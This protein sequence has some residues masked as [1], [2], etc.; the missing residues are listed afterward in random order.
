V[1]RFSSVR[2]LRMTSKRARSSAGRISRLR[3]PGSGMTD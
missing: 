1:R 3:L 2:D